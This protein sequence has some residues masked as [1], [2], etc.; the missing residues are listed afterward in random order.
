MFWN[1]EIN[2]NIES[3]NAITFFLF[4]CLFINSILHFLFSN[5]SSHLCIGTIYDEL[6][7]PTAQRKTKN[8]CCI[9]YIDSNP[10]LFNILHDIVCIF[11]ILYLLN[12]VFFDCLNAKSLPHQFWCGRLFVTIFRSMFYSSSFFS[13]VDASASSSSK[14]LSSKSSS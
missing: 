13:S 14:K 11:N 9:I 4:F 6:W 3:R 2:I 12:S 5:A 1:N 10:I 8:H 7:H